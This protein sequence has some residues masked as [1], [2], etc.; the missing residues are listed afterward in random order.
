M[1]HRF[2]GIDFFIRLEG[3]MKAKEYFCARSSFDIENVFNT[4]F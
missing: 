3:L 2:G 4:R 1:V